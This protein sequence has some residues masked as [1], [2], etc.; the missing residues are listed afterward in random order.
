MHQISS[1]FLISEWYYVEVSQIGSENV[2][3]FSCGNFSVAK[4]LVLAG[5]S[6]QCFVSVVIAIST[7]STRG[8][9]HQI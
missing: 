4:D 7:P 2:H 5:G 8:K 3:A 1:F 6:Q 9:H